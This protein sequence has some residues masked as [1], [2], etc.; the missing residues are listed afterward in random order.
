VCSFA[1]ASGALRLFALFLL[2]GLSSSRHANKGGQKLEKT[3]TTIDLTLLIHALTQLISVF[4][5]FIKAIR[6]RR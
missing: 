2:T 1:P 3:M 5:K 4:T 6:H